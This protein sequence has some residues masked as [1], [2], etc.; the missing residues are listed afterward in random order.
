MQVCQHRHL[1]ERHGR[2][3]MHRRQMMQV[4]H[5]RPRQR[6]RRGQKRRPR[7]CHPLALE[8]GD[9]RKCPVGHA[10]PGLERRMHRKR[11]VHRIL[12]T[13]P[14]RDRIVVGGRHDIYSRKHGVSVADRPGLA[15]RTTRQRHRPAVLIQRPGKVGS[16]PRRTS[17]RIEEQPHPERL[18]TA[19]PASPARRPT[20]P[21]VADLDHDVARHIGDQQPGE[22]TVSSIQRQPTALTCRRPIVCLRLPDPAAQRLRIQPQTPRHRRNPTLR[23]AHQPHQPHRPLTR[24]LRGSELLVPSG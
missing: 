21:S 19:K 11:R 18:H 8:R 13:S 23:L 6:L 15:D 24:G 3:V 9:E 2:R 10:R 16:H 1:G 20:I 12:A 5:P 7:L 17:T 4:K 22:I 14:P